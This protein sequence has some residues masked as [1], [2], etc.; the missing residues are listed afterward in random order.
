MPEFQSEKKAP[1]HTATFTMDGTLLTAQAPKSMAML[2]L[3]DLADLDMNDPANMPAVLRAVQSFLND[4]LDSP[5]RAHI[6]ARLYDPD[7]DFDVDSLVPVLHW[8]TEEFTAKQRPTTPSSGSSVTRGRTGRAS[9]ARSR[10]T[11]STP[12]TSAQ[13]GS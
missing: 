9:T 7:D 8:M 1:R 6:Q 11:V 13:T 2:D 10:S 3:A 4:C 12:S 5:S